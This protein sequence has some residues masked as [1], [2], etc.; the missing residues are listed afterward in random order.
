MAKVLPLSVA[1]EWA[2][3]YIEEEG[4]P[5]N[6][7]D[8]LQ[9]YLKEC[10]VIRGTEGGFFVPEE[11]V[12]AAIWN[13]MKW[14]ETA[15]ANILKRKR[16]LKVS[17]VVDIIEFVESEEFMGMRGGIFPIVK[18]ALWEFWHGKNPY[19]QACLTGATGCLA[20]NVVLRLR[21]GP[22]RHSG[23]DYTVRDAFLRFNGIKE[24]RIGAGTG[25][26]QR[27]WD[28]AIQTDALSMK[29]DLVGFNQVQDIVYSGEQALY[30]VT[31]AAGRKIRV[32]SEH[33]FRVPD[34]TEGASPD[35]FKPLNTLVPGDAVVCQMNRRRPANG[36]QPNAKR[37]WVYSIPYH[38]F[39][40]KQV[41]GGKDYKRDSYARLAVEAEMNSLSAKEFIR[42][43]RTDPEKAASLVYL[44]RSLEV[45]HKDHKP[46]N[47]KKCNL[48]VLTHSEHCL[49]HSKDAISHFSHLSCEVDT[50][51][52]IK[53]CGT[54]NTFDLIMTSPYRNYI[55]NGFVVHN[56]GKTF[57]GE[58]CTG[59]Q[60]YLTWTYHDIQ[61]EL[62]LAKG[63]PIYL[64]F[65]AG[66]FT[67]AKNIVMRPFTRR[68]QTTDFFR[69][70]FPYN[71]MVTSEL[72]F[73]NGV[74]IAPFSGSDDAVL[75]LT[76]LYAHVSELNRM[77]YIKASSR[78]RNLTDAGNYD[79]AVSIYKTLVNRMVG[80][81]MQLGKLM[82]KIIL[83]AAS[84]HP[85]DFTSGLEKQAEVQ[86]EGKK[87]I[88]V[89][90]KRQWDARPSSVFSEGTFLVEVG[91]ANRRS[92]VIQTRDQAI[93]P[94]KVLEI[95]LDYKQWIDVPDIEG[96]LRDF[97]GE[98][99]GSRA[100]AIPYR[101]KIY[102]G[103]ENFEKINGDRQLFA[104]PNCVLSDIVRTGL[105]GELDWWDLVNKEYLEENIL[106]KGI[107]FAVHVDPSIKHDAAGLV[108][109]H[110]SGWMLRPRVKRYN[111]RTR[112]YVEAHD[113]RVPIITADGMLEIIAPLGGEIELLLI[114]ELVIFLSQVLN[115][116]IV[117][118]DSYQSAQMLQAWKRNGIACGNL[119]VDD[120]P[121]P[122]NRAK[123]GY[124][125]GRIWTPRHEVYLD[126][127]INLQCEN[128]K[129]DHL[130]NRSKNVSDGLA[131]V[132]YL[133]ETHIANVTAT[134]GRRPE[135]SQ[136]R[137]VGRRQGRRIPMQSRGRFG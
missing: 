119:S 71:K 38:P 49:R 54:E 18:E 121:D 129:Y 36:R 66:T 136:G 81:T 22:G 80:R 62:N 134:S 98:V 105:D 111:P 26:G 74:I 101:E 39:A 107:A 43:L 13:F 82:G 130:P 96:A 97:G 122:Y 46:L 89:Y 12:K 56:T 35:G 2:Y 40:I 32:T 52:S 28:S 9:A 100:A 69:K 6:R 103:V 48:E 76:I 37:K 108:L 128:E 29:E 67:Q 15:D 8:T 68:I 85:D 44:P 30:E 135:G 59:Y 125:E 63:S 127:I 79:Q 5:E 109:G 61:A 77:A 72:L 21:R 112:E 42:I 70:V 104:T 41:I 17:K 106:D 95:P 73:P 99:V 11:A 113:A 115:L 133:C 123:W 7:A 55:A 124:N 118:V 126:E 25:N 87:T 86:E 78:A 19:V 94:E 23:R 34:G 132:V 64:A 51:A 47:D 131:G 90:K 1:Y 3:S 120:T 117:S 75:G 27:P 16:G 83:D 53:S 110:I 10:P 60:A 137:K 50:I 116:A 65:Q 4:V 33:P 91:E 88:F 58:M 31:T 114:E 24:K 92:R 102:E 14:I 20:S 84:E 57:F 45:H 93:N